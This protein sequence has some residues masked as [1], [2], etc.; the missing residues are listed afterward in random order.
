MQ[1]DR[2]SECLLIQPD[3][4]IM[5]RQDVASEGH[6]RRGGR[7]LLL[8]VRIGVRGDVCGGRRQGRK[9]TT[10]ERGGDERE[11]M[12]DGRAWSSCWSVWK[13]VSW[14][15]VRVTTALDLPLRRSK[16]SNAVLLVHVLSGALFCQFGD[17]SELNARV[18]ICGR[19]DSL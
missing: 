2:P 14:G 10:R 4:S 11:C 18:K 8:F 12:T 3:L 17:E 19:A 9:E 16:R 1:V 5:H 13:F 15:D 7:A 6:R